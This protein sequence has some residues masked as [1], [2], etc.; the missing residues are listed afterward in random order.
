MSG[1]LINDVEA[2]IQDNG[3]FVRLVWLIEAARDGQSCT[4]NELIS[5]A[6]KFFTIENIKFRDLE[7][8]ASE[9]LLYHIDKIKVKNE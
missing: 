1:Q 8:L 9:A 6:R 7:A 2:P 3:E 5:H 4:M